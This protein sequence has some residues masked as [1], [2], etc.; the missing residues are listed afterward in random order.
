MCCISAEDVQRLLLA[1][2]ASHAQH[3]IRS[4]GQKQASILLFYMDRRSLGGN[5]HNPLPLLPAV[6]HVAHL[7]PVLLLQFN[8]SMAER[9]EACHL[10]NKYHIIPLMT[11]NEISPCHDVLPGLEVSISG[12][13][14]CGLAC[15]HLP[16]TVQT[17]A[18]QVPDAAH[19]H[20]SHSPLLMTGGSPSASS[21]WSWPP[22]QGQP[23]VL[24][25]SCAPPRWP[26]P[27]PQPRAHGA[28]AP[29]TTSQLPDP[30]W[31][32]PQ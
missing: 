14:V 26:N 4:L 30:R 18:Q 12:Q 3:H 27:G 17:P 5:L 20:D 16:H 32:P 28:C 13:A 15:I 19:S 11:H 29:G 23:H 24:P 2:R 6:L 9:Q 10:Q 8:L 7:L 22:T 25:A 21:A 31:L 1:H